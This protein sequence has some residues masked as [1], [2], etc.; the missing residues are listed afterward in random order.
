MSILYTPKERH[1]HDDVLEQ[2]EMKSID[3]KS[4]A[5]SAKRPQDR[6]VSTMGSNEAN[7]YYSHG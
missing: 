4:A 2:A 6:G 3:A 5:R 7:V 1:D